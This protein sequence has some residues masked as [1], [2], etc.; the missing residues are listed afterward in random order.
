MKKVKVT[1][2]NKKKDKNRGLAA[3]FEEK[4]QLEEDAQK[5][6]DQKKSEEMTKEIMEQAF[7]DTGINEKH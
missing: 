7:S 1:Q 2:K 4:I 6:K 5:A 3:R